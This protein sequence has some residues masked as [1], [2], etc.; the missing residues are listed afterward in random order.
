MS[1]RHRLRDSV[2]APEIA[3]SQEVLAP[4]SPEQVPDWYRGSVFEAVDT[5]SQRDLDHLKGR[6][7]DPRDHCRRCDALRARDDRH[8]D[9]AA[10]ETP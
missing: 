7:C 8:P 5:M 9:N 10:G 2:V 3:D 4:D 6:E 1:I